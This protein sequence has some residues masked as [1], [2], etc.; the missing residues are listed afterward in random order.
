LIPNPEEVFSSN[1]D[2]GQGYDDIYKFWKQ[3]LVNN[4]LKVTDTSLLRFLWGYSLFDNKFNPMGTVNTD[5]KGNYTFTVE[6][7]KRIM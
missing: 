5:D 3:K 6:C 2:G 1:R 4:Y 7:G